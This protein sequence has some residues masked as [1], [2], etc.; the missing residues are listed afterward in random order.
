MTIS[1]EATCKR[2]GE[3]GLKKCERA[4]E[5]AKEENEKP[6]PSEML[7]SFK[8]PD[9]ALVPQIPVIVARYE[10]GKVTAAS[11]VK[12]SV[13]QKVDGDLSKL[14]QLPAF[15]IFFSHI[16][17]TFVEFNIF[18]DT[19]NLDAKLRPYLGLYLDLMFSL[20]IEHGDV[21]FNHEQVVKGLN[22]DTV[23]YWNEIGLNSRGNFAVGQ[24]GQYVIAHI[25]VERAKYARGIWWISQ[26]LLHGKFT[27]DRVNISVNKLLNDL[28]NHK[29]EGMKMCRDVL[30]SNMYDSNKSNHATCSVSKQ[31]KF[32]ASLASADVKNM[33]DVLKDL[34][35]LRKTCNVYNLLSVI[36]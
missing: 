15:P 2:L 34:D 7:T 4:L 3:E 21:T 28:P 26:V 12:N 6:I 10:N 24:F 19:Q 32:L 16:E 23:S 13:E 9:V 31:Q 1:V 33:D 5:L 14:K 18:L 30:S 35:A 20:P 29:R 27:S 22:E 25:K 8:V 11:V 36:T 17:S